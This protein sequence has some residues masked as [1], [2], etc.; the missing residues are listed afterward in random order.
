MAV[1]MM[2][3]GRIIFGYTVGMWSTVTMTPLP[4]TE[5]HHSQ[6]ESLGGQPDRANPSRHSSAGVGNGEI[7]TAPESVYMRVTGAELDE[8]SP[9]SSWMSPELI[10]RE[11]RENR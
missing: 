4:P 10:A 2:A 9:I 5:R 6:L 11:S 8:I 7:D 1:D 3:D